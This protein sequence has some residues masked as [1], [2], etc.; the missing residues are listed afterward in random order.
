MNSKKLLIEGNDI[1]KIVNIFRENIEIR[2]LDDK[3][4]FYHDENLYIIGEERFYNRAMTNIVYFIIFKFEKKTKCKVEIVA[5]GGE[6]MP[7]GLG[8]FDPEKSQIKQIMKELQE[9]CDS[10]S[11]N[12]IKK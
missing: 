2:N 9:I 12:L 4:Y 10:N 5:G 11:W 6:N 7:I 3:W 8:R 1:Q